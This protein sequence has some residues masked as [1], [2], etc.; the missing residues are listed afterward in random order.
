M[1]HKQL[2]KKMKSRKIKVI[3]LRN[4][5][6]LKS[7]PLRFLVWQPKLELSRKRTLITNYQYTLNKLDSQITLYPLKTVLEFWVNVKMSFS[8]EFKD[9]TNC[10]TKRILWSTTLKNMTN[11]FYLFWEQ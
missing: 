3:F 8:R 5:K 7:K 1:K 9:W 11:S 2:S 4:L 10:K 6:S